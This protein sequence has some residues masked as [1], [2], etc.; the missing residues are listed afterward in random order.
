MVTVIGVEAGISD[1]FIEGG[2]SVLV[3]S[4]FELPVSHFDTSLVTVKRIY[5]IQ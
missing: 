2:C 3:L 5:L 4:S 1:R